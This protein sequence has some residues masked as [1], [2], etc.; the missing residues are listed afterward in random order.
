MDLQQHKIA[1]EKK[2]FSI[3]PKL[4]SNEEISQ[5]LNCIENAEQSGDSFLNTGDLFAI[6]QLLKNVPELRNLLFNR[7]LEELLKVLSESELFLTKAIY[8]DKPSESNWFVAY[9]QDLS[10][11]VDK[12]A[13][14]ANFSNWTYKKGQYGVQPP[15]NIGKHDND[16]NSL[17]RDA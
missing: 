2:G 13:D 6:R 10:I 1:L 9:H 4:F 8:F 17:G 11:S 7:K 3:L 5:I 15:I 14:L 16:S 12:K